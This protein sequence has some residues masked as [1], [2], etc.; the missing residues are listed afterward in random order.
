MEFKEEILE[1]YNVKYSCGC[2]HEM[3]VPKNN[4]HRPTGNGVECDRHK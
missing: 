1:Q 4:S 2:V 3:E